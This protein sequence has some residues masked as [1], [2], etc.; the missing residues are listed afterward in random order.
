MFR[1][2]GRFKANFVEADILN[3]NAALR[4]LEGT[5]NIVTITH[6]L[7]QWNLEDQAKALKE[8][9]RLINDQKYAMIVGLQIGT[10]RPRSTEEGPYLH[11][12]ETFRTLWN[13][14][15]IETGT[16]WRCDVSLQDFG[17]IGLDK[18][19]YLGQDEWILSFSMD[20]TPVSRL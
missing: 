10:T 13:E 9:V 4:L 20:R 1:D 14:V 19:E 12:P 3:P 16:E 17:R 6:L 11:S 7:H 2:L 8:V 18:P 15:E 5:M